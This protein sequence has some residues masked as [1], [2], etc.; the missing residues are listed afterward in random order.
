M[1]GDEFVK[2]LADGDPKL[3]DLGI[4][5]EQARDQISKTL[6]EMMAARTQGQ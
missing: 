1:S 6:D 4:T 3:A 5:Q 2:Q